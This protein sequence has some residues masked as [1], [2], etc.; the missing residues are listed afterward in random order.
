MMPPS[1]ARSPRVE[2]QPKSGPI[3]AMIVL[4]SS[5]ALASIPAGGQLQNFQGAVQDSVRNIRA[6]QADLASRLSRIEGVRMVGA[7]RLSANA[8][9]VNMDASMI[10][11]VKALPNVREVI[12]DQ[13]GYLD[14]ANS[15]PSIG[16]PEVWQGIP[17]ATGLGIRIGIIDSGIDYTHVNFGGS[18]NVSHYTGNNKADISDFGFDG[19]KV[20]GGYD[21][22]GE[23][24]TSS[25]PLQ[26]A[27]G[28]PLG[29]AWVFAAGDND[30]IDCA[31][32]GHGSHVAGTTAGYGV[33]GAGATFTGPWNAST[34]FSTMRIGPG[35]APQA[36]LFALKIGDCTTSVSFVA[37]SLAIEFALD[38][39]GDTNPADHL[40]V[41]NNSYGGAYG[42]AL[43]SLD[44][45][46]NL[47]SQAGLIVVTSAGNET[48][49]YFV[50]GDPAAADY[51]ISTA[52]SQSDTIYHGLEITTGDASYPSYPTVIAANPSQ[53]GATGSH[54]P[55]ALKMV[56]A[57][58]G[59]NSQGCNINDYNGFA[60]EAG[61][62][63]WTAAA[64]GCGSGTRMT[65][66]V[67]HTG[68][69]GLVVVSANPADFP[70]I[71]LAC[72]FAGGASPIPCVSITDID[73]SH[74]AANPAAFTVRFDST[75]TASL[76]VSLQDTLAGFSSRGPVTMAGTGELRLKPDITAPGVSIVSTGVG[77]G[78]GTLTESGTSMASP[79]MTGSAALMRQLHP[80]WTVP[81]IKALLMNT[82]IN[83]LW[84]GVNQTGDNYGLSRIGA[85]RVDLAQA[86]ASDVIAFSTA[87]PEHVS[88][89]FGLVEVIDTA[90]V[91]QTITVE[92]KSGTAATYDVDL[93]QMNDTPG[94]WYTASPAQV[95]VP[96]NGTALVTVTL[97]ADETLMADVNT[98]DPTT[99]TTQVGAFGNLPRHRIMEEGAYL[100]LSE[101]TTEQ[102]LRVPVWASA[103]P[104]SDMHADAP[105]A[106]GENDQG[107]ASLNLSGN[108]VFTG[109]N[110]P[111]DVVSLV[112]AFQVVAVDPVSQPGLSQADL[113]YVGVT[114]DYQSA[115][116]LC[117]GNTTCAINNTTVY[118]AVSTYGDWGTA[119]GFDSWFDIHFD[120]NEDDNWDATVFNFETGFLINSDFTDT[121]ISWVTDGD[122]WLL[123]SGNP[124]GGNFINGLSAASLETYVYNNS[125][126]VFPV[127]ATDIGLSPSNT[128]FNFD[129][130]A[131]G[132][133]FFGDWLPATWFHYDVANP[134][135]DFE[136]PNGYDG[137][138]YL[139]VPTYFDLDGGQIPVDYNV[140]GQSEPLPPILLL[141]HQ[142]A[143]SSAVGRAELVQVDRTTDM[144]GGIFKTSTNDIY[145][146][147]N[148]VTFNIEVDSYGPAPLEG[149]VV[150][151]T[152]PAGLTYVSD[153]CPGSSSTAPSGADTLVT[154][155]MTALGGLPVGFYVTYDI[156]ASVDAGASANLT[157]TAVLSTSSATMVDTDLSDNTASFDICVDP[158]NGVC[159]APHLSFSQE[160][161]DARVGETIV[162][163][164][165]VALLDS[166]DAPVAQS[167]VPVTLAIANNPSGGTLSGTLTANTDASGVATFSDLSINAAGAGY[168]L[169]A[170][171]GGVESGTSAS[172][173]I[174]LPGGTAIDRTNPSLIITDDVSIVAEG[175]SIGDRFFFM[176]TSAPTA[177]VQV[178]FSSTDPSQLMLL[179]PM[180]AGTFTYTASY[181]L[182]F[183]ASGASGA[184]TVPWNTPVALNLYGVPDAVAEGSQVYGI[185]FALTSADAAYNG[186]VVPN[187]PV[188][189]AD[190]GVTL[191][192]TSFTVIEGASDSYT[193]VLNAPPGLVPLPISLGGLRSEVVTVSLGGYDPLLLSPA[194]ANVSFDRSNWNIPQTVMVTAVDDAI[195]NPTTYDVTITHTVTSDI[196]MNPYI[197]SG[198]GGPASPAPN[199]TAPSVTVTIMDN[200]GGGA[201]T[202]AQ[203]EVG[204][205]IAPPP[206]GFEPVSPIDVP[207]PPPEGS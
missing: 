171:A 9:V 147:G 144:D 98:P 11:A 64:S 189:V 12:P 120:S 25:L 162:P 95:T 60:G 199:I 62:I 192:R 205:P 178:T 160:P 194:V 24:W 94:V 97:H 38:P 193:V 153:T 66:A 79:H 85:G 135:Y 116:A 99:P 37:A 168:T 204:E 149:I 10:D 53:G 34:P 103:R 115:L 30:P 180:I 1:E 69:A 176:L 52:A 83:D 159:P 81:E 173:N 107:F 77:T 110:F 203:S 100:R 186:L 155:D 118:V 196:V 75:L 65:N 22:V 172:F 170:S 93:Q 109:V 119:S 8:L 165:T 70:F 106:I 195:V 29:S 56:A 164:V 175:A 150:T 125:V 55:Y 154:C 82:A 177:D 101:T 161:T 88:V 31:A 157:N 44:D 136:D 87:H 13:F 90:T 111:D 17:G 78:N 54:G 207:P 128:D 96:A 130:L 36:A 179:N 198:Y 74:L 156:V 181:S 5:P 184:A 27:G 146:V 197:D 2:V 191:S 41:V 201:G 15:V 32:N 73:G 89:S 57:T 200:D 138:P 35:V 113:Q 183:S 167:G 7:M 133:F 3:T 105:V 39:N 182:T 68:V 112:S 67:N 126:L 127:A 131:L 33:T 51:A 46:F 152:L 143:R 102:L 19:S 76:P 123:G 129:V 185:H 190:A 61:L 23:G 16:A 124:V 169:S 151:D 139:G 59:G 4:N 188:T 49:T 137:G 142:N 148:N 117:G 28:S 141:H 108:D 6:Q 50:G 63:V 187:E 114:S 92:N 40:D 47:A 80:T 174:V 145:S 132:V 71:N 18:G 206:G 20:I 134:I 21:F 58:N 166:S 163:P 140:A 86:Q 84:T 202:S 104:A 91:N 26:G 158:L 122:S 45:Q 121:I 42:S 72:T 43:E 48:D 14:N